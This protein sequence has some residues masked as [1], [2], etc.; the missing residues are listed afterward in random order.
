[1][2]LLLL[3][4]L[5]FPSIKDSVQVHQGLV[6]FQNFYATDVYL[7][8]IQQS[9]EVNS[10]FSDSLFI[11]YEILEKLNPINELKGVLFDFYYNFDIIN[12]WFLYQPFDLDEYLTSD[13]IEENDLSYK[14]RADYINREKENAKIYDLGKIVV[15]EN[16][17]SRLILCERDFFANF[18]KNVYLVNSIDNRV[19]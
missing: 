2:N 16:L 4:G 14:N 13:V 15:N 12:Y 10:L 3:I 6:H 18:N 8:D 11:E 7:P 19:C 17:C 9:E 5:I 1:M